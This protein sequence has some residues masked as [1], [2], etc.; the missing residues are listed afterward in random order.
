MEYG[1]AISTYFTEKSIKSR[2]HIFQKCVSSLLESDYPNNIYIIDDGSVVDQHLEWIKTT[3]SYEQLYIIKK[4]TNRGIACN[5]N[6]GI[7]N[8]LEAGYDGGFLV[9][10]DV[11]FND[12]HWY[13]KL[14]P[15]IKG[16]EIHHFTALSSAQE[17]MHEKVTINEHQIFKGNYKYGYVLT[18][19]KELIEKIGYFIKGK[20]VYGGEHGN[21]SDRVIANKIAPCHYGLPFNGLI[22]LNQL[23]NDIK[24][25]NKNSIKENNNKKYLNRLSMTE[26]YECIE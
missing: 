24:S 20:Y 13:Q 14:M 18:F 22:D 11:V 1:L 8:I 21:F 26:Y 2:L 9:D 4:E 6:T 10:D 19:S 12:F 3:F 25:F 23:S 5:K 15:I 17:H 16:T 7:K